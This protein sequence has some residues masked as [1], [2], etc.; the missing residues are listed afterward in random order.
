V[1][2]V[3]FALVNFRG[4]IVAWISHGNLPESILRFSRTRTSGCSHHSMSPCL[5]SGVDPMVAVPAGST[6]DLSLD[7]GASREQ[8]LEPHRPAV[9]EQIHQTGETA[10]AHKGGARRASCSTA[11][12]SPDGSCHGTPTE[13]R[14]RQVRVPDAYFPRDATR[15]FESTPRIG[16]AEARLA[17]HDVRRP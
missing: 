5:T 11:R 9:A 7:C 2:S 16:Q 1:S 8:T 6:A 10:A 3:F 14:D 12:P 13:A 4:Q 17:L 15:P